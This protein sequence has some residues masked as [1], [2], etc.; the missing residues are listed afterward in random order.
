MSIVYKLSYFNKIGLNEADLV[1]PN[2]K[3]MVEISKQNK[4]TVI[5]KEYLI[6]I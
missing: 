3:M 1:H 6:N 4:L 5:H 2:Y